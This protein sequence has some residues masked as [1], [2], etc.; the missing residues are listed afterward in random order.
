MNDSTMETET[1]LDRALRRIVE[2]E[3]TIE[4]SA[5]AR[6]TYQPRTAFPAWLAVRD[7]GAD[8]CRVTTFAGDVTLRP[9]DVV[10]L[11]PD[12]VVLEAPKVKVLDTPPRNFRVPQNGARDVTFTGWLLGTGK[13][14]T[15]QAGTLGALI[16]VRIFRSAS[17]GRYLVHYERRDDLGQVTC[18]L[19]VFNTAPQL[20]TGIPGMKNGR[21]GQSAHDA[22]NEACR[23]DP[24]LK[25]LETSEVK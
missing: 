9:G 4:A 7:A 20:L 5:S 16:T 19:K 1:P 14:R 22:W 18:D 11:T 15:G 8:E 24:K 13:Q 12:G 2:L 10:Y 23:H 3:R 25:P 21:F 17:S 6:W